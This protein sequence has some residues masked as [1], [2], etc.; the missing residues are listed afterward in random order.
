MGRRESHNYG[1]TSADNSL[2]GIERSC[3][4]GPTSTKNGRNELM[5]SD[6]Q[7]A[8]KQAINDAYLCQRN[9]LWAAK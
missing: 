7:A 5:L 1:G 2:A 3:Y 9:A 4:R 8:Q 6:K